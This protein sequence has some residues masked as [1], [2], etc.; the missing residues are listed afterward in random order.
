[1]ARNLICRTC[2]QMNKGFVNIFT[3]MENNKLLSQML[4]QCTALEI[5]E[6]DGLPLYICYSCKE[7]LMTA[8]KFRTTA[9]DSYS[10]LHSAYIKYI[11]TN[12]RAVPKGVPSSDTLEE[13]MLEIVFKN[14]DV[15]PTI[16]NTDWS[17]KEELNFDPKENYISDGKNEEELPIIKS[18][19]IN[20]DA[21][22]EHK[23]EEDIELDNGQDIDCL[24]I[25]V[26]DSE[27]NDTNDMKRK[28]DTLEQIDISGVKDIR[29]LSR[30]ERLK[31]TV[32]CKECNRS[33]GYKYYCEEHVRRHK[34]DRPFKCNL[35]DK[36]FVRRFQL[37]L[38]GRVHTG[39]RP[40]SCEICGKAFKFQGALHSHKFV[41][42][43]ARPHKCEICEKAF[44]NEHALTTHTRTHKKEK[45]CTCEICGKSFSDVAILKV[46]RATHVTEAEKAFTCSNCN[47]A[48]ATNA[49][50]KE[51]FKR[52]LGV[53][54]HACTECDK[55][56]RDKSVLRLHMLRHTGE[57]PYTCNICEKRF[58]HPSTLY[59]HM[60]T[61][62]GETPYAC[63]LCPAK[64][65]YMHHR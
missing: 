18:N 38:H 13:N 37:N 5:E 50:L 53:K 23:E 59:L 56:F 43:E 64:F 44:K 4:E 1:M 21:C 35:C 2:L 31:L 6:K 32:F 49:R 48:F 41:H 19:I 15:S 42:S 55:Q 34:G 3:H 63:E 9:I 27:V 51:H 17:D 8:W 26:D 28:S 29:K 40:Y 62:T 46:H 24:E 10:K 22:N 61:H 60:R 20:Y 11:N 25:P 52:H 39:E 30:K 57:K 7:Q 12:G 33:F 45:I 36:S 65:M 14:G 54:P 58:R 47:K 16:K